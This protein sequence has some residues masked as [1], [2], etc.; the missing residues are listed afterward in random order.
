MLPF[1]TILCPTDFSEPSYEALKA[2]DEL[3]LHF[4]AVLVLV[5]VVPLVVDIPTSADFYIPS[6]VLTAEADAKKALQEVAEKWISE[7]VRIRTKVVT[8]SPADE[9]ISRK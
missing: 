1:T 6:D 5:H 7:K 2:A 4:S 3:A 8:G 9:I